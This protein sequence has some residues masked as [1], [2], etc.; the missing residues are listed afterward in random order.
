V[1]RINWCPPTIRAADSEKADRAIR[2]VCGPFATGSCDLDREGPAWHVSRA[3][4]RIPSASPGEA[5][6][7]DLRAAVEEA[8]AGVGLAINRRFRTRVTITGRTEQEYG[9]FPWG[10]DDFAN[11]VRVTADAAKSDNPEAGCALAEPCGTCG[12]SRIVSRRAY[13]DS[14]P[15][16]GLYDP[17]VGKCPA[18]STR[19]R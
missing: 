7:E 17:L 15:I 8:L 4:R 9:P 14:E 6:S 11:G 3:L 18:C 16:E 2:D 1:V 10:R 13:P 12:G 5:Q 19:R